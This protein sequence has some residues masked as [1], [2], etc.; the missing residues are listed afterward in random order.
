MLPKPTL[1]RSQDDDSI[2]WIFH[3]TDTQI[4]EAR[5]LQRDPHVGIFYLSSAS[6]CSLSCRMCHLTQTGQTQ[7]IPVMI[8]DYVDQLDVMIEHLTKERRLVNITD[9]HINF[10]ARGDVFNNPHF[11]HEFPS[12]IAQINAI[13]R[14]DGFIPHYKI[15][16]I[17]P[18][19][20]PLNTAESLT[21]WMKEHI[22]DAPEDIEIYYSLYSL[23]P[24]FRKRWLPK[25]L[26]PQIIGEVFHDRTT[27][28]RLHH[29]LIPDAND[30]DLDAQAIVNYLEQ[31]NI[32]VR[33]NL[34]HYNPYGEPTM[35]PFDPQGH[36]SYR[37]VLESSSHILSTQIVVPRGFSSK[38]S[39]GQFVS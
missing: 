5:F 36:S 21:T 10:M 31:Y 34:V 12:L 14:F 17:F 23:N 7:D 13:A 28:L 39:C 4:I 20:S 11:I 24:T 38:A 37:K 27:R 26:D 6:G 30:S 2:N 32:Y 35:T 33:L 22:W 3:I 18:Q 29:A 16:T 19:T 1:L 8:D 25:A 15:S 9:I